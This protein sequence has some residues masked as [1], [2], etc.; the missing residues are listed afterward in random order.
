MQTSLSGVSLSHLYSCIDTVVMDYR[1]LVN[2]M[3]VPKSFVSHVI[4]NMAFW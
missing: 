3:T 4:I 1:L 2:F